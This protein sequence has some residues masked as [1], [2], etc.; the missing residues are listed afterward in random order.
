VL[1]ANESVAQIAS[2]SKSMAQDIAGIDAATGQIDAG[3]DQVQ[4]SATKLSKLAEQ[5]KTLVGQFRV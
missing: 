2:V 4:A 5:L 3:G 1:E